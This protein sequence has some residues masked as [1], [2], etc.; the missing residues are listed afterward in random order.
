[1]SVGVALFRRIL[2]DRVPLS[3]LA[4]SG[5]RREDFVKDEL[6]IYDMVMDY[7]QQFGQL[8]Q[9]ETV[10]TET[11]VTI[12]EF[13]NEPLAYWLGEVVYRA[14]QSLMIHEGRQ[15]VEEAESGDLEDAIGQLR[16]LLLDLNNRFES[17][18]VVPVTDAMRTALADHD[19]RQRSPGILGIPFG[20]P[21]LDYISD[22]AQGGDTVAVVGRPAMGKTYLL[23]AM[24]LQAYLNGKQPLFFSPE[25]AV[26]QIGR[27][28]LAL[29]THTPADYLKRGRV[30]HFAR[31]G[32]CAELAALEEQNEG[33]RFDLV[34]GSSLSTVEDLVLRVKDMSPD[35]L[36]VDGAYLLQSRSRFK[37]KWERVSEVAEVLKRLASDQNI[38]VI[39]TY[40]FNRKGP[41]NLDNIGLSDTV[42]QIA[43]IA[44]SLQPDNQDGAHVIWSGQETKI[45]RLLKGRDGEQGSIRI[46]YDMVRMII[47]QLSV[48]DGQE[49]E[50]ASESSRD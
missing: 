33:R 30:G 17:D 21:Y 44:F 13:P 8:P 40:Q 37:A 12:P 7:A 39:A 14:K 4:E 5:L 48:I 2:T 38:P 41:G 28:L 47:D 35:V 24:A 45:L 46:R 49:E 15:A 1:M 3:V 19:R 10:L 11:G 26:P 42:G 34:Q 9:L 27:R 23:L 18:Y 16:R 43:S 25:M 22:G 29:F 36:Y 50:S 6:L 32:I 31:Q 20:F